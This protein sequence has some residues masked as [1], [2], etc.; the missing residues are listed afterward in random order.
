MRGEEQDAVTR[1]EAK[2]DKPAIYAP[3]AT[4]ALGERQLCTASG[5]C[6]IVNDGNGRRRAKGLPERFLRRRVPSRG[7][8][9]GSQSLRTAIEG[10]VSR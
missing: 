2:D 1:Q 10:G 9:T 3:R 6:G 4:A 7:W 5:Q 8:M